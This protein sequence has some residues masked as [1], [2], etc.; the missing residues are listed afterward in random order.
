MNEEL[1]PCPFCGGKGRVSGR[2][3]RYFGQNDYGAKKIRYG[4]QVICGRCKARGPLV[5]ETVVL[6]YGGDNVLTETE[7][8]IELWNGRSEK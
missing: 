8:A 1:K 4:V 7:R 6:G 5:T 3:I 2:E